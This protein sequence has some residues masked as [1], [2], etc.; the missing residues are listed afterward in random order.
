MKHACR[1]AGQADVLDLAVGNDDLRLI[2]RAPEEGIDRL[3]ALLSDWVAD[4]SAMMK[5]KTPLMRMAPAGRRGERC[6]L[7]MVVIFG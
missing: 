6:Q 3:M 7:N 5:R 4:S 1:F 2:H